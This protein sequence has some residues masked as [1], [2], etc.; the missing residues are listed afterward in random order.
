MPL[1]KKILKEFPGALFKRIYGGTFHAVHA[2]FS[3]RILWKISKAIFSGF[4]EGNSV[5]NLWRK[6][7][8][9]SE[10]NFR[11]NPYKI[12]RKIPWRNSWENQGRYH[13]RNFLENFYK[14]FLRR[15]PE[16]I[17]GVNFLMNPCINIC[18]GISKGIPG[19]SF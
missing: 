18:K 8:T 16:R 5:W 1:G 4:S 9:T 13:S 19:G 2:W 15:I 10:D 6:F 17:P 11:L 12:I 3:K 14:Y 7:W